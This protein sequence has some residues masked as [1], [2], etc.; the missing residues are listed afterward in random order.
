MIR[1]IFRNCLLIFGTRATDV[2]T[3][4][5]NLLIGDSRLLEESCFT[6]IN[7]RMFTPKTRHLP[8]GVLKPVTLQQ[9]C[10]RQQPMM[11]CL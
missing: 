1:S 6:W 7:V 9:T 5:P 4:Q 10:P 2:V 11:E 3:L 8:S